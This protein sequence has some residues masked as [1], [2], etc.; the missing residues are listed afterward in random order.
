ML[1]SKVTISLEDF[2]HFRDY[3]AQ[4]YGMM[5]QDEGISVVGS[6]LTRLMLEINCTNLKDFISR[7]KNDPTGKLKNDI[8]DIITSV[9]TEWF[10]DTKPWILFRERILPVYIDDLRNKRKENIVIWSAG[11]STGQE[12][13]S[14]AMM[15]DETIKK[16]PKIQKKQFFILATDTSPSSIYIASSGRYSDKNMSEG[17]LPGYIEKYFK[18]TDNIYE[19]KPDIKKMVH[20][21][22]LDLQDSFISLPTFDVIFCRNVVT[23]LSEKWR[24]TLYN[25][26]LQKLDKNGYLFIGK[27]ESL[28]DYSN[29]F[30]RFEFQQY[31]YFKPKKNESKKD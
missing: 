11:A 26:L 19:I 13:Y 8:I 5:L 29:K 10:R 17:M 12:P 21:M 30:D 1:N 7:A 18:K 2:V 9:E 20:F 27:D 31:S 23:Y 14:I 24:K 15:I 25:K 3:I 28:T 22:Q 4:E 16:E 6:K